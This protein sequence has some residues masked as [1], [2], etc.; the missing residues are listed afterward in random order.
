MSSRA[1]E[2]AGWGGRSA[3]GCVVA[4]SPRLLSKA[5]LR[6]WRVARGVAMRRQAGRPRG[7]PLE[8]L[9]KWRSRLG[10]LGSEQGEVAQVMVT[11]LDPSHVQGSLSQ[12][13]AK[14]EELRP[15]ARWLELALE[16]RPSTPGFVLEC[17]GHRNFSVHA[18]VDLLF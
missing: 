10:W 18:N 15:L 1:K 8:A 2:G 7:R 13:R 5:S 17:A 6:R 16:P 11:P 3:V 14:A 9:S 12:V 4:V